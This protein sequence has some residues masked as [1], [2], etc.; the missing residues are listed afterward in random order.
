[1]RGTVKRKARRT[2]PWTL[3]AVLA[4]AVFAGGGEPAGGAR[5]EAD[6]VTPR[7][8]A[9]VAGG[10]RADLYVIAAG[11]PDLSAALGL[12]SKEAKTRYVVERLRGF[13]DT[14]QNGLRQGLRERGVIYQDVWLDNALRVRRATAQDLDW[15]AA[16]SDLVL[17]DVDAQLEVAAPPPRVGVVW[18][19][20]DLHWQAPYG[21]AFADGLRAGA[22]PPGIGVAWGVARTGAPELW[23][24]GIT[25]Q[26]V[27]VADLDTGVRWDHAALAPHYRGWVAGWARHAG[28]WFDPVGYTDAPEDLSGHGTHTAGTIIGDDGRANQIGVAPGAA[29]IGCRNMSGAQGIGAASLYLMCFQFALAPTGLAGENPNPGLAA[30][31]TSNSW[32]CD[33][34]FGEA[35]C[36]RPEALAR[37]LDA[38]RLAGIVV[39]ASNGNSGASGCGTVT[40]A[41]AT[42]PGSLAVGA[43]HA[44]GELARFSSR[45]PSPIGGAIKPDVVA[46]GVDIPSAAVGNRNAYRLA[47]GTSMAA[48]HVAGVA[49]LLLSAAPYLRGNVAEIEAILRQTARPMSVTEKC[50]LAPVDARPNNTTG[51][52]AIDA[53]AAVAEALPFDTGF[54]PSDGAGGPSLIL[55]NRS[56]APRSGIAVVFKTAMGGPLT[57][58]VGTLGP[59]QT[60]TVSGSLAAGPAFDLIYQGLASVRFVALSAPP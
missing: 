11:W 52:G 59:G 4:L 16:R 54:V 49:A 58:T 46:P 24:R 57:Q 1:M 44:T 8:R 19:P 5:A 56:G 27:V 26:G 28:N 51:Y 42:L 23:T 31:I 34:G 33:P 15:L 22:Q 45:G 48:P 9:A 13:A 43:F 38:L 12:N 25:G 17:V 6:V 7:A 29:W 40:L 20:A 3:C 35:G 55:T 30:D 39:V 47:S 10:K 36:D 53:V 18:H 2:F 41:P 14:A 60:A 50:G 37:A 21:P 32:A